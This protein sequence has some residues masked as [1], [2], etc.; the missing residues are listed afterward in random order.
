[1]THGRGEQHDLVSFGGDLSTTPGGA[2]AQA[3]AQ[4]SAVRIINDLQWL[5]FQRPEAT[6]LIEV[7][8][9]RL[10]SDLAPVIPPFAPPLRIADLPPDPLRL[11]FPPRAVNRDGKSPLRMAHAAL[12][13]DQRVA[14]MSGAQRTVI[15]AVFALV[16]CM[17]GG[18]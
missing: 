4:A 11:V 2:T 5:V 12:S 18:Q 7:T 14:R 1:M 10:R 9:Q 3:E 13:Y 17:T 16:M 8:T 15:D 6:H